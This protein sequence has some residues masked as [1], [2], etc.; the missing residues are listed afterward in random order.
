MFMYE[1]GAEAKDKITGFQGIITGRVEYL[2]GCNQYGLNPKIRKDGK[3]GDI[4]YFDEGR[5]EIIGKGITAKSVQAEKPGADFNRD[6][7]SK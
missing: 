6:R 4:C 5:I 3:L 7:P 1:L 2:Y